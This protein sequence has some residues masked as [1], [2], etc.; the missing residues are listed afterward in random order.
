MCIFNQI[1]EATFYTSKRP[2]RSRKLFDVKTFEF[3]SNFFS[4]LM[5]ARK[6]D[7]ESGKA[8][9]NRFSTFQEIADL[10]KN[11]HIKSFPCRLD[12]QVSIAFAILQAKGVRWWQDAKR[13]RHETKSL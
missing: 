5:F 11:S 9:K 8:Q 12:I 6:T 1:E 2:V 3:L 10:P 13:S 7:S 4:P